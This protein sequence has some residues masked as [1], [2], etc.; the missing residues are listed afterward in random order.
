M[1]SS[2]HTRWPSSASSEGRASNTLSRYSSR[3]V[4]LGLL[5]RLRYTSPGPEET[6]TDTEIEVEDEE[7]GEQEET[8]ALCRDFNLLNTSSHVLVPVTVPAPQCPCCNCGN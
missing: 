8:L 4:S 6:E 5:V 3:E 2:S 1:R 7:E